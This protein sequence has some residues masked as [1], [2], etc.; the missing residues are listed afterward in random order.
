MFY[1]VHNFNGTKQ[2][3]IEQVLKPKV[4]SRL[5]LEQCL[6]EMRSVPR[7]HETGEVMFR[8]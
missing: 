1:G 6:E 4:Q 3:M 8:V 2:P 5:Y 7:N